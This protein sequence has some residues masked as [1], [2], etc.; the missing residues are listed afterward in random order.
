[1]ASQLGQAMCQTTFLHVSQS[2]LNI[3]PR[4]LPD[5]TSGR[6]SS[7]ISKSGLSGNRTFFFPDARFLTLLKIENSMYLVGKIFRNVSPDSVK[8]GCPVLS[9]PK[10]HMPSLVAPYFICIFQILDSYQILDSNSNS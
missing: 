8:F 10:T 1:M 6:K 7:K 2:I 4:A 3:Y 5:I 9:S